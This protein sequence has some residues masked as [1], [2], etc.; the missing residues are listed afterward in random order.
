[1]AK[2]ALVRGHAREQVLESALALFAE[3]GVNGTSLQMIADRLGVTKASVYYHFQSKDDIVLAVIA[4]VFDD[5]ARV[6]RIAEALPTPDARREVVLSGL[7]ELSVRH[8]RL[9]A[10][11]Y[12]DPAV[13]CVIKS[14][15]DLQASIESMR[16][17]L[18]GPEP[19]IT[20]R[21]AVS[22]LTAGIAGAATDTELRDVADP[23]LH[24]A[25]LVSCQQLLRVTSPAS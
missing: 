4:P 23:E 16:N 19:D 17:L 13:E 18:L 8:R 11:F 3:H 12:G 20:R 21:V 1:V 9:T 24:R 2:A 7:V 22:L 15:A 10:V 6:V 14:R 5:V 25:L